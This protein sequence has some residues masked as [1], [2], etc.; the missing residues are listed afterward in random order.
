MTETR[1]QK[2][3]DRGQKAEVRRQIFDFGFGIADLWKDIRFQIREPEVLIDRIHS[4]PK[5]L[6]S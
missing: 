3:D 1:R 5:F 2:S 6:N 4:I